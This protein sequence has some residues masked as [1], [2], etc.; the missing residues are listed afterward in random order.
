MPSPR[1]RYDRVLAPA[2]RHRRRDLVDARFHLGADY[3]NLVREGNASTAAPGAVSRDFELSPLG[4]LL[5]ANQNQIAR[6][7]SGICLLFCGNEVKDRH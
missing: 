4:L 7:D 2:E 6:I 1:D 3:L 5:E